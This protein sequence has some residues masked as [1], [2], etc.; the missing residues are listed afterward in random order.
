MDGFLTRISANVVPD[1]LAHINFSTIDV[2]A[3][4]PKDVIAIEGFH[5]VVVQEQVDH[6]S[7]IEMSE[8][9]AA[10]LLEAML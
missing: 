9:E 3:L 5:E 4:E 2:S 7:L 6:T 10:A 1:T 8:E